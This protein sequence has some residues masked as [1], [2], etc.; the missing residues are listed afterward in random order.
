MRKDGGDLRS[1]DI[2]FHQT[3]DALWRFLRTK[4]LVAASRPNSISR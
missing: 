2:E 1:P 3:F 4:G